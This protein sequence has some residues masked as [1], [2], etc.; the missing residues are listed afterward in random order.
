MP[1]QDWLSTIRPF[2]RHILQAYAKITPAKL[3]RIAYENQ[4]YDFTQTSIKV[5][6]CSYCVQNDI[7]YVNEQIRTT[8]PEWPNKLE[9]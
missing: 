7:E 8:E 4:I 9:T 2:N 5:S 3:L 1:F 6:K